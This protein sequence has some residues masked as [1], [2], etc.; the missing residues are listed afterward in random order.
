MKSRSPTSQRSVARRITPAPRAT[1]RARIAL[2]TLATLT[3][4]CATTTAS[5]QESATP[6]PAPA[7]PNAPTAPEIVAPAP[8]RQPLWGMWLRAGPYQPAVGTADQLNYFKSFY[9]AD[10]LIKGRPML[11]TFEIAYYLLR[12]YGLLGA[13]AHVGSW[14][15]SG[16]TRIC[17]DAADLVCTPETI[18]TS[19]AGNDTTTLSIT[20]LGAG[21]VYRFDILWRKVGIPLVPYGKAGLDYF[22]WRNTSGTGK[23][24]RRDGLRGVGG[25]LGVE[26]TGGLALNL[27]FLEP[28]AASRAR[29][30]IG[31]SD[32]YLFGEATYIRANNFG[33][34]RRFDMSAMLIEAGL[35]LDFM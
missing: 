25:T 23:V 13:Y 6:A 17:P 27:N 22:L 2:A 18:G 10:A 8:D 16:K 14:R 29:T 4:L 12:S 26:V 33:D 1:L 35:G 32:T 34:A 20:P 24:S 9:G 3:L 30:G 5:A 11:T 15:A 19:V 21:L 28:T 31:L 7:G